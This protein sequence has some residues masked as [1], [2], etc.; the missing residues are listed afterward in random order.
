M[1]ASEGKE[2]LICGGR[3]GEWERGVK[4]EEF[5]MNGEQFVDFSSS[6]GF[7]LS[8]HATDASLN[9]G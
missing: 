9:P 4:R 3:G 2:E 7:V 1:I 8:A 6:V 5:S